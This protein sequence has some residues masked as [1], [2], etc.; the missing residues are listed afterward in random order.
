MKNTILL[1]GGNATEQ[2]TR[3]LK[4]EIPSGMTGKQLAKWKAKNE[5]KIAAA[6]A[7]EPFVATPIEVESEEV[8]EFS[9]RR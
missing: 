3:A 7:V 5:V 6:L 9:S 1:M 2:G 4:V 8:E